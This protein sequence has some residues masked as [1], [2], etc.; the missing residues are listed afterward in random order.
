MQQD[1]VARV[2]AQRAALA[3]RARLPWWFW[4]LFGLATVGL[5]GGSLFSRALP[6]DVSTYAVLWPSLLVYLAA[7]RLVR[8][9]RGIRISSAILRD[10][11]SAR[12]AGI[13]FVALAAVGVVAVAWL[14]RH[15][16]LT[17]AV[18][19]TVVVTALALAAM[20]VVQRAMVSDIREGRVRAA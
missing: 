16:V 17:W 1:A 15:G 4:V 6:G 14:T 3:E 7:D 10:Y 8:W 11:P 12:A 2:Q 5:V 13:G 20:G 9:R 18:V 19:V